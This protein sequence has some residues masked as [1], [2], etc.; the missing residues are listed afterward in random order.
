MVSSGSRCYYSR[1][2]DEDD[3][4]WTEKPVLFTKFRY[5][6]E[7]LPSW[8]WTWEIHCRCAYFEK[9][10]LFKNFNEIR[11]KMLALPPAFFL[12]G[13]VMFTYERERRWSALDI[14]WRTEAEFRCSNRFKIWL[15]KKV[16]SSQPMQFFIKRRFATKQ[17]ATT[18]SGFARLG[19]LNSLLY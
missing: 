2:Y 9:L 19:L 17:L 13:Y 14:W 7:D 15:L 1:T 18:L 11:C 12:Q 6:D 8:Q 5:L 3:C 16:C 10:D 4:S